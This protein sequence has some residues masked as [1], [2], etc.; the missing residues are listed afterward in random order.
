MNT[1]KLMLILA[2][3]AFLV[4]CAA[5]VPKELL[6]AREAY[7]RAYNGP[8]ARAA[9]AEL[10]VAHQ[11]LTKAEQSF[12]NSQ[13]SFQTLD[14]SYVAQRKAELATAA[15]TISIEQANRARAQADY[16]KTQG[17]IL[18]QTKTE[19][20]ETRGELAAAERSGELTAEQ[21]ETERQARL[22]AEAKLIG[23]M[24][25]IAAIAAVKE[26]SRGLVI[27]LSG[28]VLFASGQFALLNTAKTKLNQV[29]AALMAQD[30]NRRMVVEGHTDSQ[31][32]DRT[33]QP[34]S[35]NR[36]MAVRDYLVSRGVDSEKIAAIGL[37]SSRPIADNNS[38]EN[39]ANNRRV[40]I[41][42]QRDEHS[43]NR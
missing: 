37:G 29:A 13:D 12:V 7:R 16:Q 6:S 17:T 4:S 2:G 14:L 11:A 28:G 42:I 34:L 30:S 24:K 25:D 8:A 19:L 1:H 10:H 39:R 36:A 35:V 40:E 41:V 33:N 32:S 38:S 26:E 18:S 5:T 27:T 21:L 3:A 9:P 23:A 15:A 31:G 20:G 43:S 22:V